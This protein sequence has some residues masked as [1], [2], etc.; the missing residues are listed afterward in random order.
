MKKSGWSDFA[1]LNAERYEAFRVVHYDG[2][3]DPH[4]SLYLSVPKGKRGAPLLIFLHGGGMT[5]DNRDI[6]DGIYD[7]E[8]AI[9]EV[10]YRL[11]DEAPAPAQIQDAAQA[12]GWCFAHAEECG[13]DRARIFV[14][15]FSAGAYL[16]A[17]A[18]MN[19]A[20]LKPYG[21]HY[22]D[23]AGLALIS[24]QMTVHF[25]VK[26]DLG[27]NNGP[28]NPL[29]DEYAPLGHLTADL[30]P[31]LLITGES[32]LDM[33]AR[34]EENAFMAA[35]LRAIGHPFVRCYALP[36]HTHAGARD[37]CGH[38]LMNF[39]REVSARRAK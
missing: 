3:S 15:G 38:L 24:G 26:A 37:G 1:P 31:I 10:R 11:A 6:P 39:L 18:V 30:P 29:I 4:R 33:P 14:G 12:V 20:F 2:G 17:V 36:G 35:S 23:I 8:F 16:A 19:P 25:R 21:V 9:A 7:G 32:G 5:E 28:R 13:V 22:R 34:P 27:R